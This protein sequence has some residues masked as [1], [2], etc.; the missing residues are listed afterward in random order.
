MVWDCEANISDAFRTFEQTSAIS[1][2]VGENPLVLHIERVDANGAAVLTD[3]QIS[4]VRRLSED[5]RN[6]LAGGI[7]IALGSEI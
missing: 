7:L 5:P 6:R 3:R 4:V 1:E 2:S